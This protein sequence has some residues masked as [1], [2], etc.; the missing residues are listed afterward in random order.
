[1]PLVLIVEDGTGL[2]NANSYASVAEADAYHEAHLYADAWVEMETWR[3]EA[4]LAQATRALDTYVEWRGARWSE[5]QALRW[6]RAGVRDRD[7]YFIDDNSIPVWLKQATA[8]FARLLR[9]KNREADPD[10]LGISALTVGPLSLTLDKNDRENVLPES[11]MTMVAPFGVAE[12][13]AGIGFAKLI[14]A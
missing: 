12:T 9:E 7:G 1:M 6:P 8:E 10:T 2:T 14:R 4:A 13:R 11:V 3:K 5:N